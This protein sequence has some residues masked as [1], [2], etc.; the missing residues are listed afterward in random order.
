MDPIDKKILRAVQSH[1]PIIDRPF[2]ALGRELGLDE[3][4]VIQRLKR[5]KQSGVIRRIGGNFFSHR[6]GFV[7]TLCAA[8]VPEDKFEAFVQAVNAYPGVTHNYRREHQY[9]VWFTFIAESMEQIEDCLEALRQK[10]GVKE[11]CSFPAKKLFKIKVDFP[12]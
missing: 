1:L 9:N 4:E 2:A 6:L 3:A 11:I 5:L 10:T 8:R 12:V 7:S